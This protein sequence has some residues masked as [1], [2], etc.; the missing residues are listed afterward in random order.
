[1]LSKSQVHHFDGNN[2]ELGKAQAYHF[3]CDSLGTA[4][5]KMYRVGVMVINDAGDSDILEAVWD[6]WWLRL[7]LKGDDKAFNKRQ[8]GRSSCLS[9]HCLLFSLAK[10]F[11]LVSF[12]FL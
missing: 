4:C 10:A 7:S 1:M 2:V 12:N 5:G 3:W 11:K 9:T 8:L 6:R